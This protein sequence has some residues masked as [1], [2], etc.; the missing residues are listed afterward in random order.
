MEPSAFDLKQA[1]FEVLDLLGRGG[2]ADV[3]RIRERKLR[4][5]EWEGLT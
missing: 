3:Y 2:F 1:G 5:R 4:H